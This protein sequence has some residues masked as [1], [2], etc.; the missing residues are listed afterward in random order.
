MSFRP[1]T[2][3][4]LQPP[5]LLDPSTELCASLGK[6]QARILRGAREIGGSCVEV[7][8]EG[9]RIVLDVGK[10]LWAERDEVVSLPPVAGLVDGSDPS[11]AGVVIS[12]PHLD[13]YGLVSQVNEA[14]P[15]FVGKEAAALLKAAVFFSPAGVELNPAG[16]LADRAPFE[17]GS[18]T[19]T[20]FLM[21]HSAFDSYS[22]LIEAEG[23]RLFYTGDVRGHGRKAS[24]F[25]RLLRH[26][27]RP[28][29]VLLCEGTNIR[30]AG[31]EDG[32]PR[33]ESDVEFSLARRMRDTDG[34]VFVVSSAQNIDRLVTV[35]RAC[36]RAGRTLVTDLYTATLAHATGRETIPQP[37]FPHYEVLVPNRQRVLVKQSSQFDRI[38]LIRACRVFPEELVARQR[39]VTLL[40]PSSAVA[41]LLRTGVMANGVVIWS[42]WPGYLREPS[43]ERLRQML[44][45]AAVSLVVDHASGHA[46]V[47]DLQRLAAALRPTRLVR[48]HTEAADRFAEFFDN[49]DAHDDGEWWEV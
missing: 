27:P 25:E 13:H 34:A 35:Y 24:L 31:D 38:D 49:V 32:H 41:E 3:L 18:F 9:A 12:H 33:S 26:P 48:I 43:G 20:P 16:Y 17:I 1:S 37:G 5:A 29:D 47:T 19:V 7:S 46:P 11:L 8:A 30:R 6:M 10:P 4:V 22:L 15:V 42:L 14:V 40:L 21:D 45:A 39:E 2:V 23:R 44:Q 36:K 28:V